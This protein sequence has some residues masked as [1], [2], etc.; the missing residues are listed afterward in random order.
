MD[1]EDAE[2][3]KI[4]ERVRQLHYE[5]TGEK[6]GLMEFPGAAALQAVML[7][8]QQME[9]AVKDLTGCSPS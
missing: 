9:E 2:N 6:L 1:Y 5:L 4:G 7:E 8:L 3:I